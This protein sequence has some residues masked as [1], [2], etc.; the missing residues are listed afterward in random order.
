MIF[1]HGFMQ[2]LMVYTITNRKC[3]VL[4]FSEA[5]HV[6]RTALHLA[7]DV[8]CDPAAVKVAAMSCARP[9]ELTL[10]VRQ[11][12]RHRQSSA[13]RRRELREPGRWRRKTIGG[14]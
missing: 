2:L 12:A 6:Q 5:F 13:I 9:A 4:G 11:P 3:R 7:L 1:G 14:P 8:A 10:A